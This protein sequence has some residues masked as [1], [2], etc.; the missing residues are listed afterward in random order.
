LP[1]RVASKSDITLISKG[2]DYLPYFIFA[3]EHLGSDR[4]IGRAIE[5]KGESGKRKAGMF[6][7]ARA[8]FAATVQRFGL[9]REPGGW[10]FRAAGQRGTASERRET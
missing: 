10:R 7:Q 6:K 5:V 8:E 3:F 4:G 1:T 9:V 2:V